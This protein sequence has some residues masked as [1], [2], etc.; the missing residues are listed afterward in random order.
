MDASHFYGQILLPLPLKENFVWRAPAELSVGQWV[1]APFGKKVLTGLI[2][3]RVAPPAVTDKIKTILAPLPLPPVSGKM[4]EFLLWAARYSLSPAGALLK[5]AMGGIDLTKPPK[6]SAETLSATADPEANQPVL[7]SPQKD[8]A[9][10][11]LLA[12]DLRP[13][14]LFGVTGSGKTEV[15]CEAIAAKLRQGQQVLVLMPEIALTTAMLARFTARFGTEPTLWHSGLTPKRRREH[16]FAIAT[17]KAGLII[18]ARSALFLP[19]ADLGM[20][21]VDEEH[22]AAY[23][24]EEPPIYHARDLA[25]ARAHIE[26]IPILLV[27]ATPSLETIVNVRQK[28]YRRVDLPERFGGAQ[29]PK[30]Q[31]I[32][33]RAEKLPPRQFLSAPL[34]QAISET[35]QAGEQAALFLNRRGYAPLTLCRTCGYRLQCPSCSAWLVEHKRHGRLQCHHCGY[36]T[37]LPRQCTACKTPESFAACGPGVERVAEE[38]ALLFPQARVAL[39]VSDLLPTAQAAAELM[40]RMQAQAIDL[41]I[42]TQI[43]AK[44]HHFPNLTLVGVIDADL[45][46]GGGDPRAAERCYQLLQQVAGRAGRAERAGR[47]LLQTYQPEHP[48]MQALKNGDH[49]GFINAELRERE[50]WQLP[51]YKKLVAVLFE[52]SDLKQVEQDA[53][54]FAD[55]LRPRLL[56][57]MRLLGPAPAM[58]ALLRGRHRL[59][60]LLVT[61]RKDSVQNLLQEAL[62]VCKHHHGTKIKIDVDPYSFF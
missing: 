45:G 37:E 15:Y 23:K 51:P 52:N 2:L 8:A 5:I 55:W 41:L 4:L 1:Q 19:Y 50:I 14:L 6:V 42:G 12:D 43:M 33:M 53:V 29:L 39:M 26:K 22:E 28:K 11:L 54:L 35:F 48:I 25:V 46:L 62:L 17:G 61:A 49:T 21:I 56:A 38:A 18:G 47:A 13:L 31:L 9:E 60:L 59:R 44:G 3:A 57:S 32:D 10:Q 36:Q 34:R 30:V 16:W 27:S 58:M 7:S 40:D 20:L 24:Q